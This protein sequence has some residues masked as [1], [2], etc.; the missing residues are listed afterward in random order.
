MEP[1][2]LALNMRYACSWYALMQANRSYD[3]SISKP[4]RDRFCKLTVA[5]LAVLGLG[6]HYHH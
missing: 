3:L 1:L 5:M 6:E 4:L 2:A